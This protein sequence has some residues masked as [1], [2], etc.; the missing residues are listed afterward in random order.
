M[1]NKE[2]LSTTELAGLLGISR[3]AVFKKIKKGE[4]KA[5]KIGRNF[6]IKKRD[7]DNI[8]GRTLSGKDKKEIE[9][10]VKKVVKE[11]GETLKL[12]GDK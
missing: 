2:F 8:L 11:Y 6:V 5:F 7:L 9:L 12:L 4:I 3:I 1:K 10:A